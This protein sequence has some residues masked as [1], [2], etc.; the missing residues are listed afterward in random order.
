MEKSKTTEKLVVI[1]VVFYDFCN[2]KTVD[3]PVDNFLD[4]R[5]KHLSS[6]VALAY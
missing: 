1:L 5:K 2:R 3:K 4:K 6:V